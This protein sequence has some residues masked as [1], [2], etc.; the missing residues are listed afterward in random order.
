MPRLV[1]TTEDAVWYVPDIDENRDD[2]EPFRVFLRTLTGADFNK[3]RSKAMGRVTSGRASVWMKRNQRLIRRI[4]AEYV[5]RV[6]GYALGRPDGTRAEPT[7]GRELVKEIT[8][9]RTPASE[10]TVLDDIAQ[11]LQKQSALR[12]GL[13]GNFDASSDISPA[14][15]TPRPSTNGP[16]SNAGGPSLPKPLASAGPISQAG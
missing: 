11:A 4:V 8:D 5:L 13:E 2:P 9:K 7:N 1:E 10:W 12:D 16:A 14:P 6:E 3:L 15:T